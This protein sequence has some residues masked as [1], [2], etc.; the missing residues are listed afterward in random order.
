MLLQIG[1]IIFKSKF[2]RVV[3]IAKPIYVKGK[4]LSHRKK[5]GTCIVYSN[6]MLDAKF[7][8]PKYTQ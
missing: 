1:N 2:K 8:T 5:V 3:S 7:K 4:V 6:K